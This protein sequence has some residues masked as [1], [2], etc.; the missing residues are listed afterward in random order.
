VDEPH[1]AGATSG[2][3]QERAVTRAE[4]HAAKAAAHAEARAERDR[5][6][7]E[8][9]E[10]LNKRCIEA[11]EEMDRLQLAEAEQADQ[12]ALEEIEI[13]KREEEKE[14]ELNEKLETDKREAQAA[15]AA[16]A[17][18]LDKNEF[19]AMKHK[20]ETYKE[21][22]KVIT[23]R[24][25]AD[26][27][28]MKSQLEESGLL[29]ESEMKKL[30]DVCTASE[31][32]HLRHKQEANQREEAIKLDCESKVK[33]GKDRCSMETRE[34]SDNLEQIMKSAKATIQ[35][36]KDRAL[37][38]TIKIRE[39]G[40]KIED[41]EKTIA[42]GVAREVESTDR[43]NAGAQSASATADLLRE[44]QDATVV[45]QT[46]LETLTAEVRKL[47]LKIKRLE[48]EA[49][50]ATIARLDAETLTG[51]IDKKMVEIMEMNDLLLKEL[52][53]HKRQEKARMDA[54]AARAS[55]PM[56]WARAAGSSPQGQAPSPP[57]V[58]ADGR[59]SAKLNPPT[60]RQLPGK[61]GRSTAR[62]S[63]LTRN[64][65]DN[66]ALGPGQAA[67]AA[68][69]LFVP[70]AASLGTAGP[71]STLGSSP[72]RPVLGPR[73]VA[74]G[75]STGGTMESKH[76]DSDEAPAGDA[77]GGHTLKQKTSSFEA[78]LQD[79]LSGAPDNGDR[80]AQSYDARL[81]NAS[82]YPSKKEVAASEGGLSASGLIRAGMAISVPSAGDVVVIPS[83]NTLPGQA[84]PHHAPPRASPPKPR[85]GG[86]VQVIGAGTGG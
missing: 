41:N 27:K 5:R 44:S 53:M 33:E 29:A 8:E 75:L 79:S 46:E 13:L 68:K 31:D 4:R 12:Q 11:R 70:A 61:V 59:A 74:Q 30:K 19:E 72:L 14:D 86:P 48:D 78:Y 34:A 37:E 32:R 25:E 18:G 26:I 77:E 43:E 84:K 69:I 85:A 58:G 15:A 83:S 50:T 51:S 47:E 71:D 23:A 24:S 17:E 21:D 9:L 36:H 45:L 42:D 55:G 2:D 66:E 40:N 49:S 63:A 7:K 76:D 62:D 82:S 10:L 54:D 81:E 73:P 38:Q 65:D 60:P 35:I 6:A 56:T 20:L 39:L 57:G 64:A 52:S 67:A 28:E 80:E 1:N 3:P 22:I 16:K